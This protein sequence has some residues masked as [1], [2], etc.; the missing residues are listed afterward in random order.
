M[1]HRMV[2]AEA[3]TLDAARAG[4]FSQLAAGEVVLSE[5]V[6]ADGRPHHVERHAATVEEACARVRE[7]IPEG[8]RVVEETCTHAP[9]LRHEKLEAFDETDVAAEVERRLGPDALVTAAREVTP[10]RNGFLGIGRVPG[11]WEVDVQLPARAELTWQER[12]KVKAEVGPKEERFPRH[13]G[14]GVCDVCN[15]PIAGL[16]AFQVPVDVFY[17]SRAYRNY[18]GR[19]PLIAAIGGDVDSHIAHLRAV[20]HSSHSAVCPRCIHMFE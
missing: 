20:D 8:A 6:V 16:E 10:H 17:G 7:T 1:A 5:R 2:V 9:E 12:A 19:N 11:A 15:A 18:L 13:A 14:S 3:D 4:L